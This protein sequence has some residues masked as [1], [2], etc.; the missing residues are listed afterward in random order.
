[1]KT[2]QRRFGDEGEA[3]VAE[4]LQN[5][6]YTICARNFHLRGGE[7]DIIARKKEVIAFVEVKTR[8]V[9]QFTLSEVV[10]F[11]KQRKIIRTARS[12]LFQHHV[13][14]VVIRFDVALVTGDPAQAQVT[15]FPNAFTSCD[16]VL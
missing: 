3:K 6:G 10:T 4:Y 8:K 14:D 9:E 13:R 11:P 7:I 5:E 16:E 12:Y 2:E 15:Y 1:M